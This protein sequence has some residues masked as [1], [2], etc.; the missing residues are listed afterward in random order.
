M[1]TQRLKTAVE[2]AEKTWAHYT[3]LPMSK[4]PETWANIA[5]KRVLDLIHAAQPVIDAQAAVSQ[6]PPGETAEPR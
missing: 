3:A 6:A 2:E 5:M 4:L 1:D